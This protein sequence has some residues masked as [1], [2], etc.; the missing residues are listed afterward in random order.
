M[1]VINFVKM[2]FPDVCFVVFMY[3]CDCYDSDLCV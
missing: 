1:F 2:L 3:L